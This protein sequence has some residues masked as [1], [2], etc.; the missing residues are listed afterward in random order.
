MKT[1]TTYEK[2]TSESLSVTVT[3]FFCTGGS[4]G[5]SNSDQGMQ[6]YGEGGVWGVEED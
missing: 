2:P 3:N 6:S 1:K 4:Q 5:V